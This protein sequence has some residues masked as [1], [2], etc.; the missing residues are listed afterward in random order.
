MKETFGAKSD[1]SMM[2]RFH[3]QTAGAS[4]TLQQ[5]DNNIVR[6]TY[7]AMAAVLGGAQSLHTNSKDEA[8]ALPSEGA[9]LTALRTQQII[10]SETG[11]ASVVDP[12]GGSYYVEGLTDEIE[13][14][15]QVYF[16]KIEQLGG[17]IKAVE[18]GYI[19][20]EIQDAAYQYHC[21]VESKERILVGVNEFIDQGDDSIPILSID[22]NLEEEQKRAIKQLKMERDSAKVASCLA[23]LELAAKGKA[24]LM[25]LICQGVEVYAT[26]GEISGALAKSFGH[27]RPV[28]TF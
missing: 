11:L 3:V 22:P 7:E 28:P 1:K 24:N 14:K 16:K 5:P 26:V 9:A 23:E 2:L 8:L 17:A 20:K 13:E 10:A 12:F 4:L 25:P 19:Q 6:T 27:F 21:E 15:I 18:T